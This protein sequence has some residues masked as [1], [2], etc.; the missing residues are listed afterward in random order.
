MFAY[1]NIQYSNPKK[2]FLGEY[3]IPILR[4]IFMFFFKDYVDKQFYQKI[5]HKGGEKD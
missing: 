4:K 5:E 1:N 3:S 2:K